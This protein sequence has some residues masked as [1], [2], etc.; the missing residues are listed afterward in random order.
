MTHPVEVVEYSLEL[1]RD[2]HNATEI[3]RLV[4]LPRATVR[5]WLRGQVPCKRESSGAGCPICGA[6]HDLAGLP[7]A[8]THLLGLYLGDGCLSR[9]PRG[10]F[11]LRISLDATRATRT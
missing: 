5:D 4:G 11:K 1:A 2:G 6:A 7:P 9:H 3:G 8:Y 10:V